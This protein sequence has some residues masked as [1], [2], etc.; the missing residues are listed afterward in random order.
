MKKKKILY[1]SLMI[2]ALVLV[3]LS[4][5]YAKYIKEQE[6]KIT[7]TS[8]NFYFTVDLLGDT[9][10]PSSLQKTFNL[11]GGDTKTI[12]FKIQNYFDDFRITQLDTKYTV[13]LEVELP[14]GSSYDENLVELTRTGDDTFTKS[15]KCV[16]ECTLNIPNGYSNNTKVIVTVS[17]VAP[18][19]KVM[20]VIFNLKTFD[21][22][23]GFY[24][25]DAKDSLYAELVITTNVNIP[26]GKLII[27][28]SDINAISNAIQIDMTNIYLL[29]NIDGVL[30]QI[31]N[32]IPDGQEYL[33]KVTNTL[34][35]NA[36]EAITIKFFKSDITKNYT[37]ANQQ[38]NGVD[39][40]YTVTIPSI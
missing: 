7:V 25:T 22:E 13:S 15:V 8:D 36:G 27:D 30:K 5:V 26:A 37:I 12:N 1:F 33:K 38:C 40:I 19:S 11:Y 23:C 14:G 16:D 9:I 2:L 18:Y 24:I 4:P 20:T 3:A 34:N 21:S 10:E 31:T 28:F 17:S 32:K 35:I 39:S 29:D 6:S